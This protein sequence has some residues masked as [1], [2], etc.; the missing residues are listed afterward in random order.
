MKKPLLIFKALLTVFTVLILSVSSYAYELVIEGSLSP[1]SSDNKLEAIF[2]NPTGDRTNVTDKTETE[3]TSS[4]KDMAVV[5]QNGDV[6]FSGETGT[7]VF[8]ATYTLANTSYT[9]KKEFEYE[10][11]ESR[12]YKLVIKDELDTD[13]TENQLTLYREYGDDR[14]EQVDS[15]LVQWES[16]D[17]I[18]ARVDQEG[19]V[20]FTGEAGKVTITAKHRGRFATITATYPTKLKKLTINQSLTFTDAFFDTPLKLT[21]TGEIND[22]TRET[23]KYPTW[24]SSNE[25]VATID[26]SGILKLTGQ[27]GTT[28]ITASAEE[29]TTS[30]SLTVPDNKAISLRNIFF[31]ENIFYSS[32]G[33][34]LSLKALYDNN[35]IKDISKQA[36]FFSSNPDIAQFYEGTLFFSGGSGELTITATYQD[37]VATV[38]TFI[39]PPVASKTLTGIKF[40]KTIYSIADNNTPVVVY[41]VNSDNTYFPIKNPQL[42]ILKKN[43][44]EIKNGNIIFKGIPGSSPIETSYGRFRDQSTLYNYRPEGGLKAEKIYIL[45]NLNSSSKLIPLIATAKYKDG[46]LKDISELAVWNISNTAYGEIN[47]SGTELKILE[48]KDFTLTAYYEGLSATI[49]S[50]A[51]TFPNYTNGINTNIVPVNRIYDKAKRMLE[52]N[53]YL[54]YPTDIKGH[55]AERILRNGQMIGWIKGFPDGSLRPDQKITRGEFA[56]F[57]DRICD[58]SAPSDQV[59]KDTV[60]HWASPSISKLKALNLYNMYS[61]NF[62]P[63]D[64][65]TREEMAEFIAKLANIRNTENNPYTDLS[66]SSPYYSSILKATQGG[67]MVG[68]DSKQFCP[69]STAT[70]AQALTVINNLLTTDVNLAEILN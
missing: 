6:V 33:Q 49:G 3:W 5:Y 55:W 46:T 10:A 39:Y 22:G 64:Y 48:N 45:T 11:L 24:T 17:K 52:I 62:R 19:K 29:R 27:P 2:I 23:I 70:R 37:Q 61:T 16:S 30:K 50:R 8:T 34:K 69:K 57:L 28:V 35:S 63:D 67:I 60:N 20:I 54:P 15:E 25:D 4:N 32:T 68:M 65:L 56:A 26:S 53:Q 1:G 51:Y 9:G 41:G 36:T 13:L 14:E 31:S 12:V 44:G 43:I 38:Q 59:Y 42:N 66:P 7:V 40:E 18:V 21:V 58:L 47:P